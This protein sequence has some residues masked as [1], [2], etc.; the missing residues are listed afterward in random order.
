MT[1]PML[2]IV[3]AFPERPHS[4]PLAGD[5]VDDAHDLWKDGRKDTAIRLLTCA[6]DFKTAEKD[7]R[8]HVMILSKLAQCHRMQNDTYKAV[9][10][11]EAAY[12]IDPSDIRTVMM[13]ANLRRDRSEF[14]IAEVLYRKG[15]KDHPHDALIRTEYEKLIENRRVRLAVKPKAEKNFDV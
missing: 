10:L 3:E 5:I 2:R 15:I 12:I 6:L 7:P 13:L 14:G 11:L 8:G 1:K 9:R 4:T